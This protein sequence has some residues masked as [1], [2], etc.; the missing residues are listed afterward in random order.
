MPYLAVLTLMSLMWHYYLL[1]VLILLKKNY[2]V[3]HRI[4]E[5]PARK[6]R[7]RILSDMDMETRDIHAFKEN[8]P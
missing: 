8:D 1:S 3:F 7:V 4:A 5:K 2:F 6:I